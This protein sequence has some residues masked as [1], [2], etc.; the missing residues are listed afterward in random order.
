MGAIP[1][2][3]VGGDLTGD[4]VVSADDEDVGRLDEIL[5]DVP[6]GRIAYAVLSCGGVFGIGARLYAVPWEALTRDGSRGC[7]ILDRPREDLDSIAG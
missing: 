1:E 4:S 7:F 5:I 2:L 3:A 6:S